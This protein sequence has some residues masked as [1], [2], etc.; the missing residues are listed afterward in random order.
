[1]A[2]Q[3]LRT[4]WALSLSLRARLL[5]GIVLLVGA[6]LAV[7]NVSGVLLLRSSLTDR[8]DQQLNNLGPRRTATDAAIPA[9][10]PCSNPRDPQGLR[11]DFLI[12]V[13]DGEGRQVCVLGPTD[14]SA[15]NVG[16][17]TVAEAAARDDVRT[18]QSVDGTERWRVRLEADQTRDR[19]VVLAVS[20]TEADATVRRMATIGLGTSAL[21]LGLLAIAAWFLTR[22]GLRPLEQIE[23]TAERIAAGDLTQRVPHYRQRTEVGRLAHAI[24]G[25]LGQIE[26][27]FSDRTR[28]EEKLRRFVADAS[29]ELRTPVAT[30]RGHAEMY[31]NGVVRDPGQVALLM[32]RVESESTRIGELVDDMLLLARLDQARPLEREP[33][34]LL[35]LST[36]TVIDAGARQPERVIDIDVVPGIAPPVVTG[37][38]ARLRQVLTN[39]LSNALRHTP[40]TSPVTVR[41]RT[42]PQEA[43]LTVIDAGPGMPANV[44]PRVFDRFYRRDTGRSREQGGTGLGLAI[45]YSLV[46]AHR[47][48]VTC[49]SSEDTGSSFEVRLPL[50]RTSA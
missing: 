16:T 50:A 28:S 18:V 2:V 48:S 41:I 1:M 3:S 4:R 36:E 39:L 44:V 9:L 27:A 37:D 22:V 47:G 30:I 17:P 19:T 25:M 6:G 34:D 45:V 29:H 33:V 49:T 46:T 5:V 12:L 31:R 20:L 8:V 23:R 26:R 24:N 38:E 7:A 32:Q 11:A 15:P 35:A 10:D 14:V 42:T 43:V 21:V 13:L 40:P